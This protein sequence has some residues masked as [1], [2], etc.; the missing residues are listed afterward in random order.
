MRQLLLTVV[1]GGVMAMTGLADAQT[2]L[3]DVSPRG[4]TTPAGS[5]SGGAP[6]S[7]AGPP[8]RHGSIPP[9][10]PPPGSL[11]AQLEAQQKDIDRLA[12]TVG[13]LT[14]QLQQTR[15]ATAREDGSVAPQ[16]GA[17]QPGP[18]QAPRQTHLE[19]Q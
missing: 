15:L 2:L 11:Q 8:S 5:P 12:Q 6:S 4:D 16:A 9:A 18:G 1:A 13:M 19:V 17:M 7:P 3:P 10:A 14:Q